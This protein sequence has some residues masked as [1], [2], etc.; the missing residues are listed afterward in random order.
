MDV[1]VL[2]LEE[3]LPLRVFVP[4]I[5]PPPLDVRYI[6]HSPEEI[7][8]SAEVEELSRPQEVLLLAVAGK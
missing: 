1:P 6:P 3:E 8:A 4:A 7:A 5:T 2:R